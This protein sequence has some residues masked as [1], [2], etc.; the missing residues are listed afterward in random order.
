MS[1]VFP[2]AKA[3]S[4]VVVVNALVGVGGEANVMTSGVVMAL[5]ARVTTP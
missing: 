1:P 4:V 3:G 2:T 5:S